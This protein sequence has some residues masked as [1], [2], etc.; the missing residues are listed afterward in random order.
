MLLGF[1][2]TARFIVKLLNI[3]FLLFVEFNFSLIHKSLP[4]SDKS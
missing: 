2:C 4:E 1:V 3:D